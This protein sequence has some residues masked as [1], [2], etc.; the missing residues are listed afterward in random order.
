MVKCD[1]FGGGETATT[2]FNSK[3]RFALFLQFRKNSGDELNFW[4]RGQ[5]NRG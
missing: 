2:G 5:S 4:V 1:R 3:E